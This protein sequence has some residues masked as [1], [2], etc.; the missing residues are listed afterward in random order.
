M[1]QNPPPFCRHASSRGLLP[2]ELMVQARM[3]PDKHGEQCAPARVAFFDAFAHPIQRTLDALWAIAQ[4]HVDM[5]SASPKGG[6]FAAWQTTDE[7]REAL[8]QELEG[9]RTQ[10]RET[11]ALLE[12]TTEERDALKTQKS[13][14]WAVMAI[15]EAAEALGM[16]VGSE[17]TTE[18]VKAAKSAVFQRDEA[19]MQAQW[20]ESERT[21]WVQDTTLIIVSTPWTSMPKGW[22]RP[23]VTNEAGRA[24]VNEL[25]ED[26]RRTGNERD[27]WKQDAETR[28][29]NEAHWRGIAERVEEKLQEMGVSAIKVDGNITGWSHTNFFQGMRLELVRHSIPI[30]TPDGRG[31][32][33]V[34][35]DD[36]GYGSLEA[37]LKSI[38]DAEARG[39][40]RE[41][42]RIRQRLVDGVVFRGCWAEVKHDA[43]PEGSHIALTT[44][45]LDHAMTEVQ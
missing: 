15:Q 25:A 30:P 27:N 16:A 14:A 33:R 35:A 6:W 11:K 24:I 3:E 32:C 28:A 9:L 20:L 29:K 8:K 12:K 37:L 43:Q 44:E 17:L 18:F 10:F 38:K 5:M 36:T 23:L 41:Q 19:R 4:E 40:K 2:V 21:R 1:T 7:D 42:E 26:W 31:F 39:A 45:F 22:V 34:Y 13:D